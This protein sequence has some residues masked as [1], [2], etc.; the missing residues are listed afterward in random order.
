MSINLRNYSIIKLMSH[1]YD[2][3]KNKKRFENINY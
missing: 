3:N 2:Q 1:L